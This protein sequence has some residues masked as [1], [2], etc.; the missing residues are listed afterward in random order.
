SARDLEARARGARAE[1]G[2]RRRRA[3][4]PAEPEVFAA[5]AQEKLTKRLQTRVEIR[6]AGRG[7]TIRIHFH[8]E[9]ELMRLYEHLME[10]G[11]SR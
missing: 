11:P 3:A 1:A 8:A 4:G 7:G 2:P 6:R 5:A 9:E 10:R